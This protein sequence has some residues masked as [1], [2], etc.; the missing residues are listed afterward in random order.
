[1]AFDPFLYVAFAGGFAVGRV[2]RARSVWVGRATLASVAVLVA[3]LGASLDAVAPTALVV[4]VPLALAF[5]GLILGF[6]GVFV[7]ALVRLRPPPVRS[8]PLAATAERVPFSVALVGALLAGYVLGAVVRVPT[9]TA[10]PW[11]LYVLLALVAFDLHLRFRGLER[12]WIAL[13]AAAGGAVAAA[14]VF[15]TLGGTSLA[16][17]F[18]TSTGFGFYSLSGPLVEARFGAA[19]GLL[20]F[21]ANF[22]RENLTMLLAPLV[23]RRSGADGVTA[24]GGATAMDTTLYFVTRY[25]DPE[26]GSLAIA[27]GLVLTV[28]ASLL[29]PAFVAL[30]G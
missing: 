24:F 10:I 17:S 29:V 7:A 27:S 16:V 3:L 11:A 18:A 30:A 15:S 25:G 9:S 21:L 4:E 8:A 19:L 5:V 26:A 14:L 13:T 2:V 6:T 20:A 12:V 22:L 23:G 1:M 28:A